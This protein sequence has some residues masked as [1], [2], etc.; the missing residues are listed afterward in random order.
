MLFAD[1]LHEPPA[2]NKALVFPLNR[3]LPTSFKYPID[4]YLASA[5]ERE[6][7]SRWKIGWLGF[8]SLDALLTPGRCHVCQAVRDRSSTISSIKRR[9]STPSDSSL[10]VFVIRKTLNQRSLLFRAPTRN[11]LETA[12]HGSSGQAILVFNCD[13][14]HQRLVHLKFLVG[15]LD[16]D[17]RDNAKGGLASDHQPSC[18]CCGSRRGRA[19]HRTVVHRSSAGQLRS[20]HLRFALHASEI[21]RAHV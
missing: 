16:E 8:D 6:S 4:K 12:L 13:C 18:G 21:G 2:S 5:G 10:F 19:S 1:A 14:C 11:R 3:I 9:N 20:Q 7:A 15:M 17:R